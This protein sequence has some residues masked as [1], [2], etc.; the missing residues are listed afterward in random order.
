MV[1]VC[2]KHWKPTKCLSNALCIRQWCARLLR[3]EIS[4]VHPQSLSNNTSLHRLQ[5]QPW[6]RTRKYR[7]YS[8]DIFGMCGLALSDFVSSKWAHFLIAGDDAVLFT[9]KCSPERKNQGGDQWHKVTRY[10][11]VVVNKKKV[12]KC[13][14]G[15][16]LVSSLFFFFF[17]FF[18]FLLFSLTEQTA[19]Q[20]IA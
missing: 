14:N 13:N 5:L 12:G 17:F 19:I 18:F 8:Q 1:E 10:G 9:R 6:R 15:W 7:A 11:V 2:S 3:E 16:V 4:L 20:Q